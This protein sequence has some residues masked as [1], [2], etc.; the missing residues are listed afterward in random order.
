MG[1]DLGEEKSLDRTSNFQPHHSTTGLPG[2]T[3]VGLGT[4]LMALLVGEA[5]NDNSSSIGSANAS[6]PPNRTTI[7]LNN[8]NLQ[9]LHCKP[10]RAG[11]IEGEK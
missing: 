4:R 1:K 7:W 11:P 2:K 6:Y 9:G 5:H 3:S 10:E 8:A